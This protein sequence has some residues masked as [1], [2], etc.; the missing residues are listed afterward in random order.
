M[1]E[2]TERS[3]YT[4]LLLREERTLEA[5]LLLLAVSPAPNLVDGT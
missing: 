2:S 5:L 1:A 3:D 4:V